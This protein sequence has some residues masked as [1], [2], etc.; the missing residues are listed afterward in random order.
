MSLCPC[1]T[2]HESLRAAAIEPPQD[3]AGDA[4]VRR[5]FLS[6]ASAST[7]SNRRRRRRRAGRLAD[8]A[9]RRSVSARGRATFAATA[10]CSPRPRA[11]AARGGRRQ[12]PTDAERAESCGSSENVV[13]E[14]A[15][16]AGLPRPAR[17]RRARR[18]SERLRDRPRSGA[19]VDCGDAGA[20]RDARSRR[21]AGR[22]GARD[23]PHPQSRRPRDDGGRR[24]GRRG[25]AAGGLGAA[26]H[27][28]GR[29]RRARRDDDRRG[30]GAA[31]IMFFAVWLV[32]ILLA[33]LW[34]RCWR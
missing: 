11:Q 19:R 4:R 18:R 7:P 24:A 23:E 31:G 28:V 3:L 9:R 12:R 22:R 29:R 13:D 20:A 10:P 34:R 25:G 16:A 5:F 21:A 15:I 27:D 14:M 33:P 32:A 26:R 17:L 30:G 2:S 8:R 6:S 1:V